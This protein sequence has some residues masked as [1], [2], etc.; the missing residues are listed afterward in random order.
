MVVVTAS[1][2]VAEAEAVVSKH[3][4]IVGLRLSLS[5]ITQCQQQQQY[6]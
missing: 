2:V 5:V 3:V 4:L 6:Q 1:L